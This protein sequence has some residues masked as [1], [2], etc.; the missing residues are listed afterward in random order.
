MSAQNMTASIPTHFRTYRS[1]QNESP[2]CKIWE[3]GRATSAAPTFFK[4][5]SIADEH[6]LSLDF[7]DGGLGCNNPTARIL[8]EAKHIFKDRYISTVVSVGTGQAKT[9][10]LPKPGFGQKVL[11]LDVVSVLKKIATDCERIAQDMAGRFEADPGVYFRFNVD[12]G[13]QNVGLGDWE[14]LNDVAAHTHAYMRLHDNS[15]RA[16][17]AARAM[18][19]RRLTVDTATAGR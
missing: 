19:E 5:I 7:I 4:R 8:A 2:N 3:A 11:P 6:G 18:K 16:D 1:F 13:L 10:A 17:N 9:I 14:K 12:Q 15:Q